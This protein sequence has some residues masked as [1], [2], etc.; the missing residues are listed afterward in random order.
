MQRWFKGAIAVAIALV[1]LE[2]IA[3]IYVENLWFQELHFQSVFWKRVQWQGS[4]ALIA[5]A[6]SWGFVVL[7]VRIAKRLAH[8]EAAVLSATVAQ[9]TP[10]LMPVAAGSRYL[11]IPEPLMGRKAHSRPLFL[12]ILLP[13]ITGLQLILVALVMYYVFITIQVWTPDYTLPN[14][15]PAVPQPFHIRLL[16]VNFSNLPAQLAATALAGTLTLIGLLRGPRLLPGL[17]FLLS[18]VWGMLLSGNWFR[19]LLSVNGQPFNAI[20]P[21]F[22]RDISFYIF[23]LPLWQLLESWWRGLFLFSLLGVTLIILKSGNSLSEGKFRGFSPAQLRHLSGL[24]S[25]VALT[26]A[27]EHWLKRYGYLFSNHGVVYGANYTDV[28]WR[29]P[30]ETGLA[31]FT[32]AIAVWLAWLSIKGWPVAKA[33]SPQ[34]IRLPLITLWLPVSLYFLTLLL[35]NLGGWAIELLVVQPNQLT[36]ERPYLA[37][38]ITATR[39]AFNLQIIQPTTLTGRGQLTEASLQK[40][41][42]TL[43]NIR[44]WDPIPLLKT[45]RQ[46]QQIR[47]YYKFV[48][49]D[50]DRYTIKVQK[51]DSSTVSMAKQQTLIAPR[52][53]DY[54]A[55]P[56]KAQ[57]WV[58][59]HLVYTHGYGFTLSPVNLVDQGGLPYYFVKDIGTDQNEGA[60]RTSSELIRTSIPIGKPRIYFGEI[61]DNYIMTNTA[62]PE[63]DFPSGEENVYN[64]YDGRGGIFL[65][66][67]IRKLLFAVYLRDWQMLFTENF[68]PDTRVL[69]RRNINR[70]IRHIAPFLRFDRDP[71]LVTATVPGEGHSTLYWL[72]D[73]Y[74]TSNYYPYSDPGEGEVNQPARNFNYIRNSVKIVVDAYNGD[75]RFFAIDKQDP[76]INAWQ[77]IFPELFLPF[78]AMPATLKSHIRYPVDMFSTQSERLLTYHMEDIDVFY[79]REDQWRIPQETYADEQQPIAPYYLIMKLA[80]INAKEEEFVL[81]QVY[82]P[83]ARNNLIALLFARCDEQNYGKLLLYTLPKERLVYGPEQIEA[84]VNQDP[85]ISERISLWNRRGSRAIQ[86]NLLV[87]PIEESL[88]YVEP[89]YLEAEKNSL[90]T[91]AR[92]VVVYGNQIVM[93]DSLDEAIDAIF[94]PELLEGEAIIR[95]LDG[96]VDGLN[97]QFD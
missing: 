28:H 81:S 22:H 8:R 79:N 91:L 25:A 82:T 37:R 92:V 46:L 64:F 33:T 94:D 18:A 19:L 76:L 53:L 12:P 44:L 69:F 60:L 56:E 59:R 61:T 54:T 29:L 15:T 70:R 90:P 21:Q 40:N 89:I 84:L 9:S 32:T 62:I 47:L 3:R 65:N 93:A 52:E 7:Q 16:F 75:V 63:L 49:A 14:I 86:G 88:L 30:V 17:V 36:R 11:P 10:I 26:L 4:I 13:L 5:G 35:Q 58:N 68:K 50:L 39:E 73:A 87:I 51:Q 55:V 96:V 85:V 95:P 66:S 23:H 97:N 20:D 83:N 2:V 41:R 38:N 57:T 45:N 6:I 27:V 42:V 34:R 1:C 78:S 72:I 24:G 67:P 80:G 48:D 31:I 74:T 43:D 71:Y 77:K